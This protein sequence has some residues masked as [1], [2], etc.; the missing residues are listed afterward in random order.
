MAEP[1]E[2]LLADDSDVGRYVIATM[3]RRA[4]FSVRE[5]ADGIEAIEQ[6][7][8]DPP[9]LA[10]FDV[11]MPGA[12]GLEACRRIKS[13]AGT[14][15]VPVLLLSATFLEAADQVEGL[16]I[17]ADAYLTQPVEAPVLIA[18][19]NSLI[20]ARSAERRERLV[21]A[22]WRVTFDS[23]GDA[24]AL[25]DPS[26][27]VRR[28]NQAFAGLAGIVPEEGVGRTLDELLPELAGTALA[29]SPTVR[30]VEITDRRLRIHID[31]LPDPESAGHVVFSLRDVTAEHELASERERV[32]RR[33]QLVSSTLQQ[34]LMQRRLPTLPGLRLSARYAMG[35][36]DVAVGGD[37]FDAVPTRHGLWLAIG[38]VAGHG[39]AAAAQAVQLRLT[40]RFLAEEG[41]PPAEAMSRLGDMLIAGGLVETATAM[42]AVIDASSGSAQLVRA[43]H[44]PPILVGADGRAR[45]VDH[46]HGPV[47][48]YP[49]GRHEAISTPIGEGETL[50]F[51]TDGLVER[52]HETI[53][54]GV[55]RLRR[56]L[57]EAG[58]RELVEH[59]FAELISES[60]ADD[61]AI[62]TA[63]RF[64]VEASEEASEDSSQTSVPPSVTEWP[65]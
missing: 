51:Y 62:L 11:K 27:R 5:V 46:P 12:D 6:V 56:V 60:P 54:D 20:R 39:V 64:S 1:T 4:G 26:R 53:D 10:I 2:I 7:V 37:W 48:G 9:D 65:V 29:P 43:G 38:D 61:A 58:D 14:S 31:E 59:A 44:P 8:R 21:S 35:E 25:V 3:L 63:Q 40:L 33:E 24:V 28:C 45:I 36:A 22:E 34:A 15:H 17:G 13:N 49:G 32:F 42:I 18:S 41:Y 47:L 57:G 55:E 23:I 19:I 50:V 52:R 30:T 16:D